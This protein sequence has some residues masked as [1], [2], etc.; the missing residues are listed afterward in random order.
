[1]NIEI[2]GGD[3]NSGYTGMF[4]LSEAG[5]VS[6]FHG[7][8]PEV[9]YASGREARSGRLGDILAAVRMTREA[10]AEYRRVT[11]YS[12]QMCCFPENRDGE[13]AARRRV[14]GRWM[15]DLIVGEDLQ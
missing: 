13:A 5:K 8:T 4:F 2:E 1:M 10:I 3:E 6:I 12:G 14:F 11:G 7:E 15:P 9:D